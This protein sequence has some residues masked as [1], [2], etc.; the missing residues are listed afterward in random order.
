MSLN[1]GRERSWGESVPTTRPKPRSRTKSGTHIAHNQG[2]G[3]MHS[4]LGHQLQRILIDQIAMFNPADPAFDSIS[5]AIRGKA[6]GSDE[7]ASLW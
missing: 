7:S 6:M 3:K 2:R 1:G 4:L 5:S